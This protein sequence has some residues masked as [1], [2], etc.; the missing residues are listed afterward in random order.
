MK[1][2]APAPLVKRAMADPGSAHHGLRR[3]QP[4]LFVEAVHPAIGGGKTVVGDGVPDF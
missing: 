1:G 4:E 3:Q 2:A